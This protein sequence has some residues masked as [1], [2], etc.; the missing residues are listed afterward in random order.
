MLQYQADFRF[1]LEHLERTR[2]RVSSDHRLAIT[3]GGTTEFDEARPWNY[4]FQYGIEDNR[5]WDREFREPALLF[6]TKTAQ[7]NS[8][9]GGDAPTVG[10]RAQPLPAEPGLA[11]SSGTLSRPNKRS[12]PAPPQP[13]KVKTNKQ[14]K[15]D[16]GDRSVKSNGRFGESSNHCFL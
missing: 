4:S 1:R 9:L 2:R 12:A 7:L 14:L 6:L 11:Q 8:F 3:R 5:W 15:R 10:D 16:A 13:H